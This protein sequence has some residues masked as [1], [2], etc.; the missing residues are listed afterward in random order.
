MVNTTTWKSESVWRNNAPEWLRHLW[1]LQWTKYV[2]TYTCIAMHFQ[3]QCCPQQR[4][5]VRSRPTYPLGQKWQ[6]HYDSIHL[7]RSLLEVKQIK[8]GCF[9]VVILFGRGLISVI[10]F[11]M[12]RRSGAYH[13]IMVHLRKWTRI[14]F[15]LRQSQLRAL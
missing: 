7:F 15:R 9:W 6:N 1:N 11:R 4:L 10:D 2:T 14:A 5:M 13:S 8:A 12:S 3:S